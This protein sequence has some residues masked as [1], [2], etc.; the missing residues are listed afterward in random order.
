MLSFLTMLMKYR[1][2]SLSIAC[3]IIVGP[4]IFCPGASQAQIIPDASLG[5]DSSQ[6]SSLQMI[7]GV[8]SHRIDLGSQQGSNLFHS[9]QQFNITS[10][11]GV[12]FSNPAGVNNIFARITGKTISQLDGVLG[13]LGHANLFLLNPNGILFGP[14]ASLDLSGSFVATTAH[15]IKFADGLEFSAVQAGE[16]SLLTL[17]DPIGLQMGHSPAPIQ[18]RG[19]GHRLA[20][21][22]SEIAPFQPYA[23]YSGLQINP[24]QSI[25]LIG[26]NLYLDGAILQAPEGQITLGS[27]SQPGLVRLQSN[28]KG[29]AVDYSAISGFGEITLANR[30]SVEVFGLNPGLLQINGG[31]IRVQD[32]SLIMSNNFGRSYGPAI[33][34][35]ASQTLTVNGAIPSLNI[36]SSIS[37][38]NFSEFS[39]GD[40]LLRSPQLEVQ[41]GGA[42][43]SRN[44]G[45]GLGS[46]VRIDSQMLQIGSYASDH[47]DIFSRVGTLTTNLGR[48]GDLSVSAK[49]LA[50]YDGGF[51]G[52]VNFLQG[53][54]GGSVAIDA[55]YI[56]INGATP[57]GISS[58]IGANNLAKLGDS[59]ALRVD[60]R[61]IVIHSGG[62]VGTSSLGAGN[63][64]TLSID[65]SESIEVDLSDRENSFP[66]AVASAIL[67]PSF[68]YQRLFGLPEIPSG[69]SG[70]IRLKTP[71]LSVNRGSIVSVANEGTGIGGK[72]E[73]DADKIVLNNNSGIYAFTLSGQG[74]DIDIK[75][76][77]FFLLNGSI[78]QAT[79]FG[80][81]VEDNGG[82]IKLDAPVILGFNNSD[83]IAK[84]NQGQGGNIMIATQGLFGFQLRPQ[85]TA[86]NDINV[87]SEFGLQG[88]VK[89]H[90]IGVDPT[91]SLGSLDVA[92]S[93]PTNELAMSCDRPSNNQFTVS[94][95]GGLPHNPI[96][97]L[98]P[99][100]IWDDLRNLPPTIARSGVTSASLSNFRPKP[101]LPPVEA[102][103][104]QQLPDGRIQLIAQHPQP[105]PAI[106]TACNQTP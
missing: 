88:E 87:S 79:S 13:V 49:S 25:S 44:Y 20:A 28:A 98:N 1:W 35:E 9:F 76:Q 7:H 12:Y 63:A 83:I 6:V 68:I 67:R 97:S 103:S 85:L 92:F 5:S 53:S 86:G 21:F 52:S 39:G 93:D 14:H 18:V 10:G 51:L 105:Y 90:V 75:A 4:T 58:N 22:P 64:G 32:G 91:S 34:I 89:I 48:G 50:V 57:S 102:T 78:L 74:G 36:L 96:N 42:I 31:Q 11:E 26:G 27:V 47:P 56:Q 23:P 62:L 101:F 100:S 15:S 99:I 16:S 41:S 77:K 45:S 19:M 70:N 54:G 59:G 69:N 81:N 106:A 46:R 29:F 72:L 37:Q 94:G 17:S 84:A 55:D 3:L 60:V 24:N 66:S 43:F 82:N 80:D 95:K 104:W 71:Y 73:I 61:R 33:S 8:P 40:V 38:N 30:S 2:F 65:A